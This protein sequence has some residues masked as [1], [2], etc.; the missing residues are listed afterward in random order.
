MQINATP[1]NNG[2]TQQPAPNWQHEILCIDALAYNWR[3]R[4]GTTS[5]D[6]YPITPPDAPSLPMELQGPIEVFAA[7]RSLLVP[8]IEGMLV[9]AIISRRSPNQSYRL[10]QITQAEGPV[11][12]VSN[13][14]RRLPDFSQLDLEDQIELIAKSKVILAGM[15]R[16]TLQAYIDLNWAMHPQFGVLL[17]LTARTHAPAHLTGQRPASWVQARLRHVLKQDQPG[18]V[19]ASDWTD[20]G[21]EV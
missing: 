20:S 18:Q 12:G 21:D 14:S 4:S 10:Q 9:H 17:P 19:D 11:Q 3:L 5:V 15:S 13:Q 16:P 2:N 1:D 8:P 6:L 7:P